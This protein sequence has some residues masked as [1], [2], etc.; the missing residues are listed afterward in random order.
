MKALRSRGKLSGMN[1][2]DVA[3]RSVISRMRLQLA[4]AGQATL[5]PEEAVAVELV[6]IDAMRRRAS[7]LDHALKETSST[8]PDDHHTSAAVCK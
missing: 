7:A 8:K 6:L 4:E 5:R 1:Q 3:R 2:I